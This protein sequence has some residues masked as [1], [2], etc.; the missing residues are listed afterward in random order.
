[1]PPSDWGR[2]N[3]RRGSLLPPSYLERWGGLS[4]IAA[5]VLLAA[6]ALLQDRTGGSPFSPPGYLPVVVFYLG[7]LLLLGGLAG[8]H[9]RQTGIY[10]RMGTMGFWVAFVGTLLGTMLGAVAVLSKVLAEEST[11]TAVAIFGGLATALANLAA[12]FGLL[13]LGIATL[14]A[15]VLP[16]PWRLLP[17]AIFLVDV[18]LKP[19]A[20]L[21]LG[22]ELRRELVLQEGSYPEILPFLVWDLPEVLAG[23]CWAL[24]G[25]ALWSGT[26][27][28]VRRSA[29]AG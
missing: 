6:G 26:V 10:G 14:R 16:L 2:E 8:L 5:G 21:F 17:L 1:M 4:A 24:L 3:E 20:L 11:S 7:S 19:L 29:S 23:G 28:N 22:A 25:Y 18:L 15:G 12:G 27:K 9:A 13:L